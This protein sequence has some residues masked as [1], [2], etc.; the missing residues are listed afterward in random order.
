MQ[1]WERGLRWCLRYTMDNESVVNQWSISQWPT[2]LQCKSSEA[3]INGRPVLRQSISGTTVT[4][5][6]MLVVS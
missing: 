2:S 4:M 3:H 6:A 5:L 1:L